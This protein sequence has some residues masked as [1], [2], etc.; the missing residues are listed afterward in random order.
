MGWDGMG[1]DGMGWD[2]MGWDGMGWDGMGWD[3]MGWDGMGWCGADPYLV[4]GRVDRR[5]R[6]RAVVRHLVIRDHPH[7][8]CAVL[9]RRPFQDRRVQKLDLVRK[10]GLVNN[11][12]EAVQIAVLRN[13]DRW[14]AC[15]FNGICV[16]LAL[17]LSKKCI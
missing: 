16:E 3:G 2:G 14:R 13:N 5:L 6:Q 15:V 12:T 4:V 11:H 9:G 1:W 10:L 17:L 8:I 7:N